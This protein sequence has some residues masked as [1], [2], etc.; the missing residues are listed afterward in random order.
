MVM[1]KPSILFDSL[2]FKILDKAIKWL[3]KTG[4]RSVIYLYMKKIFLYSLNLHYRISP[5]FQMVSP[6][7][8]HSM[9]YKI[10]SFKLDRWKYRKNE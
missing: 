5:G 2:S 7:F 1:N 10:I 4:E 6:F 9:I 8:S 3:L